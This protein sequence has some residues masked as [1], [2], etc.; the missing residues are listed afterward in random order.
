MPVASIE[1]PLLSSLL[2]RVP[3]AIR[4]GH[5]RCFSDQKPDGHWEYELIVD[6]T[7]VCDFVFYYRWTGRVDE[8]LEKRCARHILNRQL[9]D[10]GWPQFPGGPAELNATVKGYHALRLCGFSQ[11]DPRLRKAR[12]IALKLGGIPRM[13]T[14]G[15][16]YL[17]IAGLFPWQYL[18]VIPVEMLLA[19]N[20]F[21][22]HIYKLSSWTRNMIVPLAVINGHKPV[23]ILDACPSL[24]ELYPEGTM[25]G[26]WSPEMDADPFTWRNFFLI[27]DRFGRILNHLPENFLR[28]RAMKVAERW[29]R[30]RIGPESDGMGAIFPAMMNVLIAMECLGYGLEDPDFAKEERDFMG[31]VRGTEEDIRVAP[32]H[33]PVWDSAI[34]CQCLIESGADPA[35]ERLQKAASWL[36]DREI[37]LR[38]D[39]K[40]NNPHPEASG[41][42]FEYNNAYYPDVD[43]TF[44]VLL[45][46]HGIQSPDP[47]RHRECVERG[48]RWTRS[49]QNEDGGFAAFDKDVTS[50]WLEGVPFA[51]HNAILDPS[52]SD[53]TGRSLEWFGTLGCDASDATVAKARNYLL[54]TQQPDGSWFGRWGVNY[55]YGTGHA[56]RGLSAIGEDLDQARFLAARDWLEE[57]QNEDGG[58]G[59]SCWTYHDAETRGKGPSTASQT[60]WAILGLLSWKNPN[61]AAIRRGVAW[62]LEHQDP[63]GGWTEVPYTGTGFP[64][65]FYL[66]Y[67][68][69]ALNWPL[70]ALGKW[71]KLA[72]GRER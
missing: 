26:D 9:E 36:M 71:R 62:L 46:L 51:D 67:T 55:I 25:A 11:D 28:E 70:M 10:G 65:V 20:W 54:A 61:R 33:S 41:W 18:P 72:E 45:G 40:E 15:R 24:D 7:V 60:A 58:W 56:L 68:S 21:P 8:A 23:R 5:E 34:H 17:A 19:P 38:G 16:L 53:I 1:S 13:H 57:H 4:R 22:F 30:E 44:Q 39:W 12:K 47:K 27:A 37:R 3:G 48:T 66:K 31:L 49:F 32:C 50:E 64:R 6:S 42:A 14:W 63:D 69:Y 59:E 29:M 35:D 52:C 43:D 2:E